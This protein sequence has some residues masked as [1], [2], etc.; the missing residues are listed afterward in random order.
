MINIIVAHSL[1]NVIGVNNTLPW[2]FPEELKVF[3]EITVGHPIVM[4]YNTYNSLN[5]ALPNRDNYVLVSGKYTPQLRDGFIPTTRHEIIALS[6]T[7]DVFIIGGAKT[8]DLFFCVANVIFVSYILDVYEGDT[9]FNYNMSH[10][11]WKSFV[12]KKTE[13]FITVKYEKVNK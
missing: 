12:Y 3:K 4:G 1:N 5:K 13:D 7:N 9:W 8:Y 10:D 6:E 2:N 11:N